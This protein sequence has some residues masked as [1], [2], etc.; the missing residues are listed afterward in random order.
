MFLVSTLD[1]IKMSGEGDLPLVYHL[2]SAR[3]NTRLEVRSL[4]L[5]SQL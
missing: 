2:Q 5:G 3:N 4:E 1:S